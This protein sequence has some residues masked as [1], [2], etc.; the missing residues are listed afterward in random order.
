MD[1]LSEDV[2]LYTYSILY[3]KVTCIFVEN[4]KIH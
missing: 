3:T 4:F 1:V 2:L